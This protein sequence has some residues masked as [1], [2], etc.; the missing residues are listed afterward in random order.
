MNVSREVI[1]DLLPL[2][3]AGE[4]SVASRAL[5]E[6]HL[7]RDPEMAERV[8]RLGAAGFPSLS[9]Q[10]LRPELELES[11]RRTRGLLTTLRWLFGLGIACTAFGLAMEFRIEHGRIEEF[12][13]VLRDFPLVLG[14]LLVIGLGCLAAYFTLRRRLR[15]TAR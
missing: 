11:L 7:S 3:L 1:Q 5:V 4:A 10:E 6:E 14:T 8:H 13:F 12:H 15:L 2:Y 9:S